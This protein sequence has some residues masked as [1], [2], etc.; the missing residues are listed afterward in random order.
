MPEFFNF[1]AKITNLFCMGKIKTAFFFGMPGHRNVDGE[2]RPHIL[3]LMDGLTG[4]HFVFCQQAVQA[5]TDA[6][7]SPEHDRG[8]G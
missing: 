3:S 2:H 5:G 6:V 4:G 8:N 1:P 7:S